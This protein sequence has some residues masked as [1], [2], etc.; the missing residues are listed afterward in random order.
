MV[1]RL[2]TAPINVTFVEVLVKTDCINSSLAEKVMDSETP[3]KNSLTSKRKAS[4]VDG[5]ENVKGAVPKKSDELSK[6]REEELLHKIAA[7]QKC[8][9]QLEVYVGNP[10]NGI[11]L[12][13]EIY[14]RVKRYAAGKP[15]GTLCLGLVNALFDEE[16][17]QNSNII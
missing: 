10:E 12:Q 15:P 7:T 9:K 6:R 8:I 1:I 5:S 16:T 4:D 13:K 14:T 3:R 17:L 2:S 11:T